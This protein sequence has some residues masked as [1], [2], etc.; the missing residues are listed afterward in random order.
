ML[1]IWTS[2]YGKMVQ[3]NQTFWTDQQHCDVNCNNNLLP[4]IIKIWLQ[5]L[6]IF[7]LLKIW[8]NKLEFNLEFRITG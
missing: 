4:K 2:D 3:I 7:N 8:N 6:N 5:F 1:T